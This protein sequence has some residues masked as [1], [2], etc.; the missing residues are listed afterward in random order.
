MFYL[1]DLITTYLNGCQG[2]G[3]V[4]FSWGCRPMT[5]RTPPSLKG[6][7]FDLASLGISLQSFRVNSISP[8][9]LV[10]FAEE[11]GTTAAELFE[12]L[13]AR[14]LIRMSCAKFLQKNLHGALWPPSVLGDSEE[15]TTYFL[16]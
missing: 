8:G 6:W 15:T 11:L 14:E 1:L 4:F 10:D 9:S 13:R 5:A 3:G 12:E 16:V 7:G 2:A